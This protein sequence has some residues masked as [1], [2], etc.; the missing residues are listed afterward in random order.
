MSRRRLANNVIGNNMYIG[1]KL[2]PKEILEPGLVELAH[3]R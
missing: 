2:A 1:N 3:L